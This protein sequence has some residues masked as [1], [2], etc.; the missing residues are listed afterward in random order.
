VSGRANREALARQQAEA[1]RRKAEQEKAAAAAG[2]LRAEEE[3]A[4]VT[5]A[6][7]KLEDTLRRAKAS[8][9][10]VK[11]GNDLCLYGDP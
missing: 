7:S 3:R 1:A 8:L 11:V 9:E 6:H 5:A 4:A 2:Q 10:K